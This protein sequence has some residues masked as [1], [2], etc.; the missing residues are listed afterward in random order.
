MQTK[1]KPSEAGVNGQGDVEAVVTAV[2]RE[3]GNVI[4][5]AKDLLTATTSLT[6]ADITRLRAQLAQGVVAAKNSLNEM[7][8][9]IADGARKT[10]A[11]TD[12]YVHANPWPVIGVSAAIAFLLGIFVARRA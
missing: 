3:V 10:A 6:G 7:G 8:G 11:T 1:T 12:A 4:A 9:A 2:S 5:D